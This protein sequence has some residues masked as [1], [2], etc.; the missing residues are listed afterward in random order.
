MSDR[1]V[2]TTSKT[3]TVTQYLK[4]IKVF[5]IGGGASGTG[6]FYAGGG[7]GYITTATYPNTLSPGQTVTVTIGAG[8]DATEA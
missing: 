6:A 1:S 3:V 5:L 7:A 2:F 4:N 8:G